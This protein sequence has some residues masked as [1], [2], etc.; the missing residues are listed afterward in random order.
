M[1]M[2]TKEIINNVGIEAQAAADPENKYAPKVAIYR[3]ESDAFP[4]VEVQ[5]GN[6]L[7]AL[8]KSGAAIYYPDIHNEESQKSKK[9]DAANVT[10]EI[11]QKMLSNAVGLGIVMH[12]MEVNKL[13]VKGLSGDKI[14]GN[15]D[16]AS[17]EYDFHP[18]FQFKNQT[19]LRVRETNPEAE[20]STHWNSLPAIFCS[21]KLIENMSETL[22]TATSAVKNAIAN[23]KAAVV[24]SSTHNL[25]QQT[26]TALKE[27][28]QNGKLKVHDD[29]D[30]ISAL[31]S[32]GSEDYRIRLQYTYNIDGTNSEKTDIQGSATKALPV[33]QVIAPVWS[34]VI[35]TIS[36]MGV[37]K[38][39]TPEAEG[40]DL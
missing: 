14:L 30:K 13:N 9:V 27:L 16:G 12:I 20:N 26:A 37:S 40:I 17:I 23:P 33:C 38:F 22:N 28:G 29:P 4:K 8:N 24:D 34:K 19:M 1:N 36:D 35:K 18:D 11:A 6:V 3:S 15:R 2:L 10:E 21:P 7:F 32:V 31:L 39:P 25:E 5:I